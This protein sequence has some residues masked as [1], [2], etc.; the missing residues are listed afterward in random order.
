[1]ADKNGLIT[2]GPHRYPPYR[3]GT[4]TPPENTGKKTYN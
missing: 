1:M 2:R 3:E 4:D